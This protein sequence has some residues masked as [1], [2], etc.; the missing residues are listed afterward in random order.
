MEYLYI[1]RVY[2]E[3]YRYKFQKQRKKKNFF[4]VLGRIARHG[5]WCNGESFFRT[6]HQLLRFKLLSSPRREKR[7]NVRENYTF[8]RILRAFIEYRSIPYEKNDIWDYK[9]VH[10][11]STFI[12]RWKLKTCFTYSQRKRVVL[13]FS[14]ASTTLRNQNWISD[15]H[16]IAY[17]RTRSSQGPRVSVPTGSHNA[18]EAKRLVRFASHSSRLFSLVDRG[19]FWPR[20]RGVAAERLE[21]EEAVNITPFQRPVKRPRTAEQK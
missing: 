10:I 8:S 6:S 12:I 17:P 1:T 20:S 2:L 5:K 19:D 18:K 7:N 13:K 9:R 3:K 14:Q 21:Y 15:L 16:L 11:P 4:L